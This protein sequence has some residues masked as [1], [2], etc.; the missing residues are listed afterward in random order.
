M[1][2]WVR[3]HAVEWQAWLPTKQR[4]VPSA[5]TVRRVLRQVDVQEVE[6]RVSR[7]VA[8]PPRADAPAPAVPPP[9]A[10]LRGLAAD[11]KAVRGV[12]AH[13]V[14]L[15]LVSLV[16]HERAQVLAQQAV[17]DKSN[18]IPTVRALLAGRDLD[19]WLVTTDALHTQRETARLILA[20][21]GHYLMVVKANQPDLHAAV[22]EWF[23]ESA[24]AEE[25]ETTWT[26]HGKRHGRLERRTLTCR[27]LAPRERLDWPGAQQVLQRVCWA[28]E[29]RSGHERQT[30][31]YAV[32]S[33]PAHLAGA[34][35]L[36][37]FWRGHWTIENQVHYV[38]D[39]TCR[40]DA[41]QAYQGATAQVL[42]ALRNGV[43]SRLRLAG[44]TNLAAA[45][46]HLGASV[47][48][49]LA[50]LGRLLPASACGL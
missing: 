8:S 50:F 44:W 12:Q 24:W 14:P 20:R 29:R 41:G 9:V 25:Q 45:L 43:L 42:A 5:A 34:A 35:D 32:T 38:R 49:V 7:W 1:A 17:D 6:R 40:E 27:V 10:P 30:L 46:R 16:T 11:G 18:E 39:V 13:G 19:G 47:P 21:R 36:E 28:Q 26:T 15:H 3:E 4:W 37:A 23:A 48:R 31:T 22:R 33:L 2:Q